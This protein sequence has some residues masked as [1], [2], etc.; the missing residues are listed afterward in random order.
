MGPK[1]STFCILIAEED[2]TVS[3]ELRMLLAGPYQ[4][5]TTATVVD[6]FVIARARAIHLLV[7]DFHLKDGTG[8]ELMLSLRQLRPCAGILVSD[9]SPDDYFERV[10]KAGFRHLLVKPIDTDELSS[11]VSSCYR[12]WRSRASC[13]ISSTPQA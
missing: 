5:C 7:T 3:E 1:C 12:E 13:C 10:L 4:V 2:E 6:G 8:I 11:I 9:M